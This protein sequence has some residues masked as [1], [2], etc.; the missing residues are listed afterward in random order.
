MLKDVAL[1]ANGFRKKR[2]KDDD[3]NTVRSNA[4]SYVAMEASFKQFDKVGT[5]ES[6]LF[7]IV[8][9]LAFYLWLRIDEALTLKFGAIKR[10][11]TNP[12]QLSNLYHSIR[13]SHRKTD[14]TDTIGHV[15]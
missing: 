13:I 8:S 6:E 15:S 3:F 7:L 10:Y 9:C 5:Y 2:A 12:H 11:L 1:Y 14:K 4:F